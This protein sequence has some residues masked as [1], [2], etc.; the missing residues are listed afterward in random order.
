MAHAL[1]TGAVFCLSCFVANESPFSER[2]RCEGHMPITFSEQTVEIAGQRNGFHFDLQAQNLLEWVRFADGKSFNKINVGKGQILWVNIPIELSEDLDSI[3]R[4]YSAAATMAHV[5]SDFTLK[6][7]LSSGV[8]I[9]SQVLQDDI[10]YIFSSE[11]ASD[12]AI[13]MRDN[14]TGASLDFPLPAQRAAVVFV[15]RSDGK[16]VGKY[17]IQ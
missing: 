6:S 17:G 5:P 8:L 14:E 15:R 7:P 11:S 4:V 13:S 2:E 12:E 16:I 10:L 9:S 1:K 3:G